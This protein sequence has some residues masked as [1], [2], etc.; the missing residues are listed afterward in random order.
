ML[1]TSTSIPSPLRVYFTL[2]L[3]QKI[4]RRRIVQSS[5]TRSGRVVNCCV[6]EPVFDSEHQSKETKQFVYSDAVLYEDW[7]SGKECD[8]FVFSLANTLTEVANGIE[9]SSER[10]SWEL[11][12]LP[13]MNSFME[14]AGSVASFDI[15]SDSGT[16]SLAPLIGWNLA[17]YPDIFAAVRE[18]INLREYHG[19]N[20]GRNQKV[21]FLMPE[22]NAFI[23]SAEQSTEGRLTLNV[24]GSLVDEHK[25]AIVGA[26]STGS[27][28]TQ[29]RAEISNGQANVPVARDTDSLE[30]YLIDQ[31]GEIFDF[32]KE[33]KFARSGRQ[34]LRSPHAPGNDRVKAAIEL[35]EGPQIE[36]KPFVTPEQRLNENNNKTKLAEILNTVAAFSNS[37]G[38]AIFI[39]VDDDCQV[40]GI[41]EKL[42]AWGN[43]GFSEQLVDK[44]VGAWR[45][46]IRDKIEG[47]LAFK[48]S[49]VE[50]EAKTVLV[51]DVAQSVS[52]PVNLKDNSTIYVRRGASNVKLAPALWSAFLGSEATTREVLN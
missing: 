46:A 34:F 32:H 6:V 18:W 39:G 23:A 44:F 26:A 22:N 15:R 5:R 16:Q 25:F 30:L 38:G 49:A 14:R 35:G 28:V 11:A 51:V 42:P 41:D 45:S 47:E 31:S 20:D 48:V 8:E 21:M 27:R 52:R 1:L 13:F 12:Q 37:G 40:V 36:F 43:A 9:F 50:T 17:F 4:F 2:H 24:A 7:L 3:G 29:L 19:E 33:G 10:R